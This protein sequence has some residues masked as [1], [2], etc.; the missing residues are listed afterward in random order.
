MWNA[1]SVLGVRLWW[2]MPSI[3][4]LGSQWQADHSEFEATVVCRAPG[5]IGLL[6]RG[7]LYLKIQKISALGSLLCEN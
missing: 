3:P 6:H 7:T 2:C 1:R 4:A 5:Q